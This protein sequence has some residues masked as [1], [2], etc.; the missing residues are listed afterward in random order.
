[1][2]SKRE[3]QLKEVMKRLE[4]GV[5]DV[6]T[7]EQY[8]TYLQTMAKFHPYSV[9]NILLIS[10]QKPEATLV[11]G[12]Q[13][14]Q[15]NFNR[16]VKRGEKGIQIF[17]PIPIRSRVEQEKVDAQTGQVLLQPDGEPETEVVERMIAR[18][19]I[20][21]VF[22]VSQTEGEP[23]P[24]LGV[25][26]LQGGVEQFAA[27]LEAIQEVSPVPIRFADIPTGAKG[28]YH[29]LRK[30]IVIQTDM[31]ERQTMKTAIHEVAHAKLHDRDW[32]K[33][34]EIEKDR[35]TREVEAESVAYTV[36]QH[37]GLDT[38]DY[39]FPYIASWS[40]GKE[41]SELRNSLDTIRQT[42][43]SFIEELT[44]LMQT[45]QTVPKEAE[46]EEETVSVQM[47]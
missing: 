43:G 12:Y 47:V 8:I 37:F 26:E 23:L 33:E 15:K 4:Q 5:K 35:M 20:V 3:D 36:C 7:S 25:E 14:W 46:F 21:T 22:D 30:E 17:A 34:Q 31:S 28:Y 9:N 16:H 2:P 24:T 39:S 32:M 13:A 1:M 45:I 11:A 44:E 41:V 6:F 10:M 19:K 29:T 18:F 42:A 40:S 27:F 38:S